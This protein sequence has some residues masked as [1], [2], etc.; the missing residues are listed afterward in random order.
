MTLVSMSWW[1]S[2]PVQAYLDGQLCVRLNW[3]RLDCELQLD[4]VKPERCYREQ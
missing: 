2:Q 1:M 3:S 4:S